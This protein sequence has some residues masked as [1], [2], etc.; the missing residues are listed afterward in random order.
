MSLAFNSCSVIVCFF[1]DLEKTKFFNANILIL[2]NHKPSLG[3]DHVRSHKKCGPDPIGSTVLTDP[4]I[5]EN[6]A[7]ILKRGRH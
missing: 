3:G 4:D 7:Y 6:V 1:V 2:T 5:I